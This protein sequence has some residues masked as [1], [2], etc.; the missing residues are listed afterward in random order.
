MLLRF[1]EIT[2]GL[3]RSS[4][5]SVKDVIKMHKMLGIKKIVSLDYITGHHI[6]KICKMLG[7]KHIM[8]PLD[9]TRQSLLNLMHQNFKKIFLE[10]GPTLI[11]CQAGKDRTGFV[12]A[13]IKCKY[14]GASYEDAMKEAYSLGFGAG[15]DPIVINTFKKLIQKACLNDK[16]DINDLNI[17]DNEREYRGDVRDSY[18]DEG[19]Q[20]SFAPYLSQIRQFPYDPVYNPLDDFNPTRENF[21]DKPIIPHSDSGTGNA[22]MVGVYDNAAGIEGSGPTEHSGAFM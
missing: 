6:D 10:G 18:L 21:N 12:S 22:V 1:R 13:F 14:L 9:G 3:Y 7:I 2:D 8:L 15:V 4:A 11:H 20:M 16:S 17:V 5:P 19:R